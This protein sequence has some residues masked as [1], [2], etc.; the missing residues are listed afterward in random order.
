[1]SYVISKKGLALIQKCEGFRAKPVALPGGGWVVGFG[2]VREQAPGA[3]VTREEAVS[4]L[5]TDLAP[6]M[7]LVNETV[8]HPIDQSQFDVLVSFAF[9]VGEI[10]FIESAVLHHLNAGSVAAAACALDVRG[11]EQGLAFEALV[12]RRA[13]EKALFLK[14]SRHVAAP[15]AVLRVSVDV[16]ATDI[17]RRLSRILQSEPATALLLT[18][19]APSTDDADTNDEIVTAHARPAARPAETAGSAR[20]RNWLRAKASTKWRLEHFSLAALLI[21]GA[22]LTYLGASL[23]FAETRATADHVGAATLSAPGLLAISLAGY[24]LWRGPET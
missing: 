11:E 23:M 21:F 24:A 15:S 9:S 3:S 2:H 7:R 8:T 18:Q 14:E 6:L 19:P 13:L 20:W 1:M 22:G 16:L 4:L 10:G 5:E 17:G 12:R